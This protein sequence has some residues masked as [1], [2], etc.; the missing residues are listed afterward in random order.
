MKISLPRF[1]FFL[2]I[3][4][5]AFAIGLECLQKTVWWAGYNLQNCPGCRPILDWSP[6]KSREVVTS[7][8]QQAFKT[9]GV[10]ILPAAISSEKVAQLAAEVESMPDSFM[11]TVLANTVLR[12]YSKY[13]H[14]LD[15][16]SELIRDWA[17]YG[18]LA[19]WAAELMNVTEARLY[20]AEKIYSAGADNPMGCSPAWHRDT[21][22]APFPVSAKS[23]T[24]NIYLDDIGADAPHGD[25]LIYVK[26]SHL[27]LKS[28]PP[29]YDPSRIFEP[30]LQVGDVL[31]H[32]PN[33]YHTPSG[34]G[35]WHRRSLQFRYVE[36]P[37]TFGFGPNRFPHGPIPWTLAHAPDVA[38]HGL[39][40]G[41]V[42]EGPWYPKVYPSPLKSEHIPLPGNAWSIFSVL[43]VAKQAQDIATGLGIGDQEECVID[44]TRSA[45]LGENYAYYG[46]DGPIMSC[47][48]WQMTSGVPVHRDGQMIKSLNQMM[49][50]S[51]SEE[52]Q[53]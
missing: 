31:A 29:V 51:G 16:R 27:D 26:G 9:D 39:Q 12:Q 19:T 24:I 50:G 37:T 42:L 38:P 20:N 2:A 8:Q 25:A 11:T 45:G 36:S 34:R 15:T 30:T 33:M 18:P 53:S 6:E 14:R 4:V 1:V 23:V 7:V 46:F 49:S 17:I 40:E 44:D 10:L 47:E 35:C 32:D 22:A 52:A 3:L 28:P 5:L 13:E 43:S 21:V 41:A 48:G